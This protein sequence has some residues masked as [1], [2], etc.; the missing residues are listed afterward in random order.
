MIK[1][2]VLVAALS[3]APS[4]APAPAPTPAP[5]PAEA[6]APDAGSGVSPALVEEYLVRYFAFYPSR[7]TRAGRHDRDRELEDFS[8]EA[9]AS[10]VAFNREVAARLEE[11]LAEAGGAR[12]DH[13]D[14]LDHELLLTQARGEL[15]RFEN[16]ERHRTNPLFWTG[17][18]GNATV[19]LLVREDLPEAERLERA[20]ARAAKIPRFVDRA[21]ATLKGA[22]PARIAPELVRIAAGQAR[23]SATFYRDGFGRV[24]DDVLDR[25]GGSDGENGDE[26]NGDGGVEEGGE[27]G[28]AGSAETGVG[29][30]EGARETGVSEVAAALRSSGAAAAEALDSFAA[31]LDDLAGKATGSPRLGAER[32]RLLFR[33]HTGI[34]RSPLEVA[35]EAEAA[36]AAKRA[37]AAAYAREV[38][39]RYF[40]DDEPPADDRALLARVFNRV[41][42][43]RASSVE[44]FVADY[45]TLV[46]EAV[47]FVRERGI[48]TLPDPL[49]L[50]TGP[51]PSYFVGQSVGGVYPAGPYAP[52][53]DTLFYLPTPPDDAS[54][55]QRDAFFRDFNHHFNVMITPHEMVPGHYLQL[56]HAARHPRKVRA[57]FGDGVYIEGWGTFCERLMLDLGWGGPLDRLA[58]LK[59]QM[60][61]IA[62]TVVD[63]RVHVAGM[64]RGEVL[65]FVKEEALQDDQFA[66]NMWVRAITSS[67]QL[68][69]YWLGYR[70]VMGLYENVK[71]ARGEDFALREFMDGM[72]EM[73]PVGVR[74]YR[75]RMLGD[76]P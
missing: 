54:P 74:H 50:W 29:E 70:R 16:L 12:H 60:E 66:G 23:A 72:M 55:E 59:K 69:S 17:V 26:G 13:P 64:E 47:A 24:A 14:T 28:P 30:G 68:T 3:A 2:L 20:A 51:S 1:S 32:Y 65:R 35:E 62:R 22:D 8:P 5:D 10:W 73:G 53:A 45:R 19:F 4:P 25:T 27:R 57:L 21:V 38:W 39:P 9:V 63:V 76:S 7:A 31:L 34:D 44:E 42:E 49:T 37:E 43:D 46:E 48:I 36:L 33:L 11:R 52:E 15:A 18:P 41:E 40:P 75:E 61:N 58:H 56:K 71:A 6:L 67:P